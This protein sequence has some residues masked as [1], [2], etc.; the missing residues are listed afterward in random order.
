MDSLAG[1]VAAAGRQRMRGGQ[2]A[3]SDRCKF[4]RKLSSSSSKS[5]ATVDVNFERYVPA[6]GPTFWQSIILIGT[7][8]VVLWDWVSNC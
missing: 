3:M 5:M 6:I 2:G 4:R 1:I 7:V 8:T